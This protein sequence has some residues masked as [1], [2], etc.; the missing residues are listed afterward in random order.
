MI[1]ALVAVARSSRSVADG[2]AK[3]TVP[4]CVGWVSAHRRPCRPSCQKI[5]VPRRERLQRIGRLYVQDGTG[6]SAG[7]VSSHPDLSAA[8]VL[9]LL[10]PL[11]QQERQVL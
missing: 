9:I 11:L 3:R 1:R 8:T 2:G 6:S 5:L 10:A 4:E 7:L